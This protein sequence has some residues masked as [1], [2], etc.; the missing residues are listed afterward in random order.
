MTWGHCFVTAN[1]LRW[2][3]WSSI[4][5]PAFFISPDFGTKSSRRSLTTD[6]TRVFE[7]LWALFRA[8]WSWAEQLRFVLRPGWFNVCQ[9]LFV[10]FLFFLMRVSRFSFPRELRMW[11]NIG[12][13]I[14]IFRIKTLNMGDVIAWIISQ[15]RRKQYR[16]FPPIS[17]YSLCICIMNDTVRCEIERNW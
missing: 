4:F 7:E 5:L 1:F 3:G 6:E 12:W 13:K 16:S 17:R 15:P 2:D 10:R 8:K 14:F 11:E 9:I